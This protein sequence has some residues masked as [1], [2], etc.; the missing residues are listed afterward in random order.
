MSRFGAPRARLLRLP[1]IALAVIAIPSVPAQPLA[2]P[3]TARG[4]VV[5]H[6]FGNAIPDP[7]RWLEADVRGDAGVRAWVDAQAATTQAY[8]ATLPDRDAIRA[9]LTSLWNFE[10]ESVPA[11]RGGRYFYTHNSG[12]QNQSPLY[13][14]DGAGAAPRLL[15]DPNRW[16]KDGATAL[17]EWLPSHDGTKLIYTV[18]DGGSDWRTIRLLDVVTGRTLGDEIPWAKI[19]DPVWNKDSSGFFYGRFPA[20][21]PGKAYQDLNLHHR[22][23]FHRIGTPVSQDREIFAT[24]D[25]PDWIHTLAASDDGR[26][27]IVFSAHGILRYQ[28]TLIDMSRPDAKPRTLVAGLDNDWQFAGASDGKLF[29]LTDRGAG[30]RRIVAFDP[31]GAKPTMREIVAETRFPL[32]AAYVAGGRLVAHYLVDA[33]SE[34]RLFDLGGKPLGTIPLPGMGTITDFKGRSGDPEAFLSLA[35]F[36]HPD[37]VYRLDIAARR[38]DILFRPKL[39]FDPGDYITEQRFYPSRDGTRIPMFLTYRKGSDLRRGASTLLYAYG[40]FAIPRTPE[41]RPEILAWIALGGV[42]AQASIRGGGEYG[43]P[44][45][46]AGRRERKQNVFD[47]FIAA[48]EYLIA[49]GVTTHQ[50]LAIRGG[51]NGGLLIGAVVNQRPD[52]FA[53]AIARVG[54]MDMLRF[55]RFTAGQYWVDEYGHPD[56]A[57]D[58]K[59]LRAYS[60]Y[61]NIRGGVDYPAVMA[62]TAD[63]DDRVVPGHSFKYIAALQHADAGPRPHLIR[64]ETRAG[65]GA[66]KP[67]DKAIAEAADELSFAAKWSGLKVE[68]RRP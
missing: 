29:F 25:H 28:V 66:G 68:E 47:D 59:V 56:R 15:L 32:Q 57:A 36:N 23:F 14:R 43:E 37:I 9:T 12:L 10:R 1:A 44:W 45:H 53:V 49:S 58:W 33:K 61:H 42:Y 55:D 19:A 30:R 63:T 40:G 17:A 20:P 41:F 18:Q 27:L 48:G 31:D 51:S 65:H 50:R 39:A 4:D 6:A 24:P 54:V 26:W 5:D 35:S 38:A 3:P 22:I 11:K 16:S 64:V 13:V 46:D 7:Y 67:T 2:Y 62:I 52:L 60:P 34:A 8:L 21:G